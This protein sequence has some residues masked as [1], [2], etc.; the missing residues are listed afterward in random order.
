MAGAG[1]AHQLENRRVAHAHRHPEDGVAA[2]RCRWALSARGRIGAHRLLLRVEV[3][4]EHHRPALHRRGEE[5]VVVELRPQ[6]AV[7]LLE[8]SRLLQLAL[9]ERV[10]RLDARARVALGEYH[11]E[12][13]HGDAVPVEELSDRFGHELAAPRPAADLAQALLVD[14]ED[15]DAALDAPGHRHAHA[16]V[17][18]DV[19]E[20]PDEAYGV[21][22]GGVSEEEQRDRKADRDPYEVLFQNCFTS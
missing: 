4:A 15:D 10:E 9:R 12:A 21:L 18:E 20:L 1:G 14:I 2:G 11:V 8:A 17:V 16:R 22:E 6:L 19:V 7:G 13:E 5:R 3:V